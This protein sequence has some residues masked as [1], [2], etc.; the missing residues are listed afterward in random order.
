MGAVLD[1]VILER[2]EA[3][4]RA[5]VMRAECVTCNDRFRETE[6]ANGIGVPR[7][8]AEFLESSS[9]PDSRSL[10]VHHGQG[11][12]DEIARIAPIL[13]YRYVGP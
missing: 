10:V 13:G 3:E 1:S 2:R 4:I 9:A 6:Q 12:E 11:H 5:R 7:T 8:L